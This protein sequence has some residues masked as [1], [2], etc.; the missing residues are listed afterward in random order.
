M[1]KLREAIIK[2]PSL[3]NKFLNN[4]GKNPVSNRDI[5]PGAA[6]YNELVKLCGTPAQQSI[7][8]IRSIYSETAKSFAQKTSVQKSATK[9]STRSPTRTQQFTNVENIAFTGNP[10]VDKQILMN[11]DYNTLN[12]VE[13]NKYIYNLLRDNNFWRTRLEQ[14]LGL[15]TTDPFLDYEF[16]DKY[17]DNDKPLSDNFEAAIE[18]N[19]A[20]MVKLL[21]DNNKVGLD[22]YYMLRPTFNKNNIDHTWTYLPIEIAAA[23]GSIDV[24]IILINDQ[25]VSSSDITDAL[26]FLLKLPTESNVDIAR[27]ILEES[28]S[29]KD[30]NHERYN[31][32]IEFLDKGEYKYLAEYLYIYR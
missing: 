13:T 27:F 22:S 12:K 29:R 26:I 15:I 23:A 17:L 32:Y 25:R 6:T 10:D 8:K 19:Y 4:P 2:N 21:M 3:C 20:D 1:K 31:R 18:D 9:S 16:I 30:V 24:L 11:L 7:N 14:K 5:K 28:L